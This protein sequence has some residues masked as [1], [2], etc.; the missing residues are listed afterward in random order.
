MRSYACSSLMRCSTRSAAVVPSTGCPAIGEDAAAG[1]RASCGAAAAGA[2]EDCARAA[3][4]RKRSADTA[5]G[6]RRFGRVIFIGAFESEV[7]RESSVINNRNRRAAAVRNSR[8]A[9][10]NRP[11]AVPRNTPRC[12]CRADAEANQAADD[13]GAGIVAAVVG[14][15][16]TVPVFGMDARGD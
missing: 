10:R 1:G 13:G 14:M 9:L 2:C 15:P 4:G 3:A 8:A 16:V 11:A 12:D 5:A 6:A 7:L